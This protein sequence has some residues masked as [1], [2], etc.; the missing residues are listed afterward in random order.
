MPLAP[1][2]SFVAAAGTA[3]DGA[4]VAAPNGRE[5]VP[6]PVAHRVSLGVVVAIVGASARPRDSSR[7]GTHGVAGRARA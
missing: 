6:A 1:L 5:L 4:G 2:A 7:P 3:I